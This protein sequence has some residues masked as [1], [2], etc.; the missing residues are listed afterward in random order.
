MPA[1]HAFPDRGRHALHKRRSF[2]MT[3]GA[4]NRRLPAALGTRS[5]SG[6]HTFPASRVYTRYV[7]P[8]AL[9]GSRS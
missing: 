1:L 5:R 6:G 7:P 9:I 4:K 8:I 3:E 2:I